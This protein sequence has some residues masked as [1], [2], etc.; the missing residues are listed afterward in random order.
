VLVR[1]VLGK[2]EAFAECHLI[3]STKELAKRLTESVFAEC[4]YSRHSAKSKPLSSFTVA[5]D[6]VSIAVT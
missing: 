4:Q 2:E 5:L 1:R 3:F 6:I